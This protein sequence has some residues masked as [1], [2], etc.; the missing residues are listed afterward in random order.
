[1]RRWYC[2]TLLCLALSPVWAAGVPG[3]PT[4]EIVL[5]PAIA[6]QAKLGKLLN[7]VAVTPDGIAVVGDAA[8]L[9][10][11]GAAGARAVNRVKDLRAFAFTPGGSLIGVRGRELVYLDSAG[12]LKPFFSLPAKGMNIVPGHGEVMVL[13]GPEGHNEYGLYTIRPGRRITKLLSSPKSVT[14]ATQAG[15][16]ILFVAG[17][18]L[19]GVSGK[20]LQLV[21]GEPGGNLTSVV[22]DPA[23][24]RIYVS[25]GQ[26][27]FQLNG[28]TVVPLAGDIGGT[29][30]WY[31]G[32]L[33]VFNARQRILV[34]LIDL[35]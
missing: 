29:L 3:K 24:Q 35:P 4:V 28:K 22:A 2:A 26:H 12:K 14:S 10:L 16:R 15:T 25:D 1:M 18:A 8:H 11:V 5:T 19:Y 17:G 23:G 34:R 13:Y 33:L 9:W 7:C 31:G 20:Q 27:V 32:G 30:R 6:E 21:A